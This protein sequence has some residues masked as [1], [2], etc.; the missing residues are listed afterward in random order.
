MQA[1][2]TPII[3]THDPDFDARLV[4]LR[5]PYNMKLRYT[6]ITVNLNDAFVAKNE[7]TPVKTN[8]DAIRIFNEISKESRIRSFITK[9]VVCLVFCFLPLVPACL[10]AQTALT[11]TALK[12]ISMFFIVFFMHTFTFFID[13]YSALSKLSTAY[14]QQS[15]IADEYVKKIEASTELV[16]FQSPSDE[17]ELSISL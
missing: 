5:M 14:S 4:K 10:I 11:S 3:L 17:D 16:I 2:T 12:V 6:S 15:K 1:T 9:P 8:Q 13:N 7:K